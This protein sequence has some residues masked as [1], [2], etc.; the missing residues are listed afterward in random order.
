MLALNMAI[1]QFTKLSLLKTGQYSNRNII[2]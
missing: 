2:I 1:G